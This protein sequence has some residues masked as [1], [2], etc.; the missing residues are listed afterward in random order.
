MGKNTHLIVLL[1]VALIAALAMALEYIP[2][3]TGISGL[4]FNYGLIPLTV[5]ALRRG[6]RPALA[7]GLAWGL[8]D[9]LLRG[10]ATGGFLNPIQGILEYPIAFTVVGLAGLA[11]GHFRRRSK[12]TNTIKRWVG[13][14][15]LS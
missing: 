6:T 13:R 3:D 1:E 4:Q 9:L 2:H 15:P 7:A 12:L 10:F 8:L 14:G 5:L 11:Y